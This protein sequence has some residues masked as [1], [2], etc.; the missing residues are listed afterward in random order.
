MKLLIAQCLLLPSGAAWARSQAICELHC[1]KR[2]ASIVQ[3]PIPATEGDVR[4]QEHPGA[5]LL[6]SNQCTL[7]FINKADLAASMNVSTE[8]YT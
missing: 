5:H 4:L 3:A 7:E 2:G 1:A 8:Q 6:N